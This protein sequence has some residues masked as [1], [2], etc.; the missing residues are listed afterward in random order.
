ERRQFGVPGPRAAA[1]AAGPGGVGGATVARP[2]ADRSGFTWV[3]DDL[4][5]PAT[6]EGGGAALGFTFLEG[7]RLLAR[8]ATLWLATERGLTAVDNASYRGREYDVGRGLPSE[9][10][11]SVAPAP[12]GV[13]VGTTR[14]L[15]VIAADGKATAIGGR[16]TAGLSL[17]AVGESLWAG[18][19]TGLALLAPGAP[20]R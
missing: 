16:G 13:W 8:G 14:G 15:A 20:D 6:S 7:R 9:D 19:A 2:G 3:S 10:V 17:L 18:T 4:S 1:S 11:T 5:G 12:D